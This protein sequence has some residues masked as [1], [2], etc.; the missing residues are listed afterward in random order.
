MIERT[1]TKAGARAAVE[2]ARC[3]GMTV[4]FVP[5]MGALHDGHLS[6]VRAAAEECDYVVAS[7]FVN[8]TQFAPGED[9][10]RYPRRIECDT[11]LLAADGVDLVWTPT[12][13]EMY[14]ADADT[15]VHPGRL[16]E[17]WEGAVRP[18]HFDGVATVVAKLLGVVAPDVA[19]FGE[20]DYQQLTIVRRLVRD[21]D[22]AVEIRGCPI[23]RDADGLALSS[24]NSYLSA[25][26]RAA[27]LALPIALDAAKAAVAAGERDSARIEAVMCAAAAAHAG[28]S[29][30]LDYA[31]VVEPTTLEPL[32]CI[33][34]AARAIIAG[35]LGAT[36]LID[37]CELAVVHGG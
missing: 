36:R 6:L 35:R 1:V 11:E 7:I 14:G 34:T 31:A 27:G 3:S 19:F 23:V 28:D 13:D 25:D 4:G 18:G 2:A 30:L 9:F 29:L 20:K 12:V 10:E 37:N 17:R 21:L 24:R 26:E 33:E 16:A 15:T 22:I 32:A 5:T 8:P